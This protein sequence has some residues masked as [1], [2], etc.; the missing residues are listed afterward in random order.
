MAS[1]L[2]LGNSAEAGRRRCTVQGP[3]RVQARPNLA[4]AETWPGGEDGSW[5]EVGTD[6]LTI[7]RACLTGD[8]PSLSCLLLGRRRRG[9]GSYPNV[10]IGRRVA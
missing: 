9:H 4:V 10:G 7:S 5:A 6:A 2:T 8:P 3:V 1:A